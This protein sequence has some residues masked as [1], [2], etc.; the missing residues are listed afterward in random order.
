MLNLICDALSMTRE[1][2]DELE[3][4]WRKARDARRALQRA[5]RAMKRRQA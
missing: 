4:L 5:A 1:H 2:R 3:A